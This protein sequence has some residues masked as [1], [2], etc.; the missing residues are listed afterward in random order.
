MNVTRE[1]IERLRQHTGVSF[2]EARAALEASGGDLLDALV[3]LER[4]GKVA[5]SGVH[6]YAT[7]NSG[8]DEPV[9]ET[10]SA[11]PVR[12]TLLRTVWR[13]L[14]DNRLEVCRRADNAVA[15][16]IPVIALIALLALAWW[17]V[18]I[19]L[20]AGFL[21]GYRYR[22]AGPHLG[23][24]AAVQDVMDQIDGNMESV[25]DQ[26]KRGLGHKG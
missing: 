7:D 18:L 20:G 5:S 22:L 21:F 6:S 23:R 1:Q 12:G 9:R 26:M 14:V 8:Y 3:W 10:E 17:L 11:Q 16:E 2:E 13:W 24:S 19:L 4:N 25:V 15:L